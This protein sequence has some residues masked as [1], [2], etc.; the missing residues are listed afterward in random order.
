MWTVSKSPSIRATARWESTEVEPWPGKCLAAARTP[1]PASP[2][3]KARPRAAT[4]EGSSPSARVST[5]GLRASLATSRTGAKSRCTP[6]ARDSRPTASP[7]RRA[8]SSSPAAPRAMNAGNS[9]APST[10][11][12]QPRSKSAHTRRG[13]EEAAWA[14][15]VRSRTVST[16]PPKR[17]NPPGRI[18]SI[19]RKRRSGPSRSWFAAG[20]RRTAGKTTCPAFSGSE[21]SATRGSGT[22]LGYG[23]ALRR[24]E[25]MPEARGRIVAAII[26]TA[27]GTMAQQAAE[28]RVAVFF[29]EG[30]P[31][32]DAPPLSKGELEEALRPLGAR[33]LGLDALRDGLER[34]AFDLL[35]L[36]HGSA[37]PKNAWKAIVTFLEEGGSLCVPG[38][39]PLSVPVR[40]E[41]NGWKVEVPQPSYGRELFLGPPA[42][43]VGPGA[44]FAAGDL[45]C[46]E[47]D[48]TGFAPEVSVAIRPSRVFAFDMRFTDRKDFD[49]EDGSSGPRDALARPLVRGLLKRGEFV[50][51]IALEIDR[52]RGRV[53][54][55]RWV[56]APFDGPRSPGLVRALAE[57]ALAGPHELV[58]RPLSPWVAAGEPAAFRLEFRKPRGSKAGRAS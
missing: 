9:V 39:A 29:E 24:R 7:T 5:I 47:G 19:Q 52:L 41:G 14:R 40:R 28:S 53:A 31:T 33:F 13:T 6:R 51:P 8:R 50:A 11:W 27:G 55:G 36:P 38:G 21:R 54:G 10:C 1:A 26:L 20:G 16:E 35:V 48:T 30:F 44:P 15:A 25:S 58:V 17:A 18:F 43:V 2:P 3:A 56:L 49:R 32:L 57:R 22:A 37:I 23:R 34:E 12:P 42:L 4:R 46:I 45:E